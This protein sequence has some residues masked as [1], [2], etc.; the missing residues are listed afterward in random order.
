MLQGKGRKALLMALYA[1]VTADFLSDLITILV[2]PMLA[3]IAL[4][5]GPSERF[6]LVVLAVSLIGKLGE[7]IIYKPYDE[8]TIAYAKVLKDAKKYLPLFQ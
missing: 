5:F 3:L 8:A 1:S 6:W 2:A 4:K 7:V